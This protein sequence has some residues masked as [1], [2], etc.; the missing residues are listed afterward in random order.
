MRRLLLCLLFPVLWTPSGALGRQ[1]P[2][3]SID[4]ARADAFI[5]DVFSR[6]ESSR[7][8]EAAE[9]YL[10]LL[11]ALTDGTAPLTPALQARYLLPLAF[12]LSD[13]LKADTDLKNEEAAARL[14][15]WWRH[16][17]NLPATPENERLYEHLERT[18]YAVEKYADPHLPRGYDERAEIYI[19]LGAP[20]HQTWIEP[21]RQDAALP[22]GAFWVYRH[23]HTTAHYLFVAEWGKPYRLG[24]PIDLVPIPLRHQRGNPALLRELEEIYRIMALF[25][26][27]GHYGSMYE[28][29]AN[30]TGL[31]ADV[32]RARSDFPVSSNTYA[33]EPPR[34]AATTN[35]LTATARIEDRRALQRRDEETPR[36]YS[37]LFDNTEPLPVDLRWARFLDPDGTTRTELYWSLRYDDLRPSKRLAG[38]LAQNGMNP[39]EHY[40][41]DLTVI[42]QDGAFAEI[43]RH[44]ETI[45]FEDPDEA[46]T[47]GTPVQTSVVRG[48]T[49]QYHLATQWEAFWSTAPSVSPSHPSRSPRIKLGALR[50][51]TLQALSD[52]PYSLEM[53]DLKPLLLPAPEAVL[54]E[55]FPYP[56]AGLT[57]DT[58]LALTFDVYHL[59]FGPDDQTHYSI[60]YQVARN[61]TN[62]GLLHV[63][64]GPSE[65]RT[66]TKSQATS[67]SRTAQETILLDLTGWEGTGRLDITVTVTDETTGQ[68]SRRSLSFQ[69]EK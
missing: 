47:P 65:H 55:A 64:R 17:D 6:K 15:A 58:P 8:A 52:N 28:Q 56:Y 63:L 69:M 50:I 43:G 35:R 1:A 29:I 16:R 67:D 61:A 20:S 30:Y 36:T 46:P 10:A 33:V 68:Q 45:P 27:Q 59:T 38:Q 60:A 13:N 3:D 53:S 21:N 49:G 37:N 23:V 31:M 62:G 18:T 22:R 7:Y 32:S 54:E 40:L 12:I 19:R 42:R 4:V 57:P 25:H 44:Q 14:Q 66:T 2:L 48:D 39:S 11:T 9:T 34:P 26:P 51:D 41:L 5:W 24:Q